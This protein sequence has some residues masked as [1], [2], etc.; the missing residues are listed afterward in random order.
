MISIAALSISLLC[1][2]P[3][4]LDMT[5][6]CGTG[7]VR[8]ISGGI[9]SATSRNSQP[10]APDFERFEAFRHWLIEKKKP[11]T[12]VVADIAQRYSTLTDTTSFGI[13]TT[14][15]VF[16]G[17]KTA[18]VT[19]V[20]Y[21]SMS[22]P[23]CKRLFGEMYD[24]LIADPNGIGSIVRLGVKPYS[25]ART[26]RALVAAGRLG[27]QAVLLKAL[28]KSEERVSEKTIGRTL[29]SL[30]G[31]PRKVWRLAD[32]KSIVEYVAAAHAEAV[33][34]GVSVTPTFFINGHRYR[35]YKDIRWV[36]DAV[37][38]EATLKTIR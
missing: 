18:P 25:T 5:D 31:Q 33:N 16:T 37:R 21:V 6:T 28:S 3:M 38:F 20:M 12:T 17:A 27:I 19:V 1:A 29:D 13:D 7:I 2:A 23:L 34:N 35:S 14:G 9:A 4:T 26:D 8:S 22:C 15:I 30:H 36:L 32:D 24:S 10:S 11:C